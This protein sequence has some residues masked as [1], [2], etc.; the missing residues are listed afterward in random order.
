MT[1]DSVGIA[2]SPETCDDG[3]VPMLGTEVAVALEKGASEPRL[4]VGW[5][6]ST[7]T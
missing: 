1:T 6:E 5:A 2:E 7:E 3:P 4:T